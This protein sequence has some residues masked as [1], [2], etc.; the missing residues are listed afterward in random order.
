M[1]SLWAASFPERH[2]LTTRALCRGDQV[3][4]SCPIH[5]ILWSKICTEGIFGYLLAV[6][7]R[8]NGAS[9]Q[10]CWDVFPGMCPAASDGG[11]LVLTAL[12]TV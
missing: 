8:N 1:R 6:L 5:G 9:V 11:E 7:T 10:I 4:P 3:V 2:E 12:W